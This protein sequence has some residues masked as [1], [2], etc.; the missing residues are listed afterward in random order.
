MAD[1]IHPQT[2][3]FGLGNFSRRTSATNGDPGPPLQ[4][5]SKTNLQN[6][7]PPPPI[8]PPVSYHHVHI[9][10]FLFFYLFAKHTYTYNAP[11]TRF[12]GTSFGLAACSL[13]L[14]LRFEIGYQKMRVRAGGSALRRAVEGNTRNGRRGFCVQ[15]RQERNELSVALRGVGYVQRQTVAGHDMGRRPRFILPSSFIAGQRRTL[16]TVRNGTDHPFHQRIFH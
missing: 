12:L 1:R 3:P 4:H 16:A 13:G 8:P 14:R 11:V 15:C 7:I 9:L 6:I 10:D 2:S 5:H